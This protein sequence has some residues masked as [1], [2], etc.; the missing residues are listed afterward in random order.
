[1]T[2]LRWKRVLQWLLVLLVA[3]LAVDV[4]ALDDARARVGGG[5]DFD[6]RPSGGG[7][8]GGGGGDGGGIPIELVYLLI[9]LVVRY[10]ALGI[11]LVLVVGAVVVGR[12]VFSNLGSGPVS[13][14]R[15]APQRALPGTS[16]PRA[17]PIPGLAE[18]R[19]RDPGFSAVVLLDLV[20]LIH[21]RCLEA[22]G[23]REWDPLSP[24]VVHA[25]RDRLIAAHAGVKS[26]SDVVT[27]GV[28]LLKVERRGA[29]DHLVV[30]FESTRTE[31]LASGSERRVLV[32]EQW[33][34]RRAAGAT[35]LPP[36]AAER[37]G[38]PNCGA[39]IEVGPMGTC[40]ACGTP[41]TGGQLQ[42]QVAFT[43][44]LS[45]VVARVPKVTELPGGEEP[46]VRW[47][48]VEARDLATARA[49][50]LQRHPEFD[51]A[52]FE[53]RVGVVFHA[54]QTA[55]SANRWDDGRPF[56]T[57]RMY[58]TL[59][60]GIERYAAQGLRNQLDDVVLEQVRVAK[61]ELDAYY[62]AITV[63]LWASCIDAIVDRTG[64]VVGG[65]AQVPR[66]F[67]EYWT[68][69]RSAEGR[70]DSHGDRLAC[71]SCGAPL[72]R[73]GSDG[74]CGYCDSKITTGRFDW[75]LTRIEQPE[76]YGG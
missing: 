17:A 30:R 23:T 12:M 24:F 65:N 10:P 21:R 61:I 43:D 41:I 45:R 4:L 7:R 20:T 19:T 70:A 55:V 53:A 64:G 46:A 76:V 32:E 75:V 26:V 67:T 50:L 40:Q 1:M 38:C 69:V 35:S 59:R 72:D 25:A 8:G 31:Q 37:L 3:V 51:A 57:D 68:F 29:E 22:I 66:R 56:V 71:P 49:A 27:G 16:A 28:R 52:A 34:F 36:A 14:R 33:T 11:P 2:P 13:H 60:F 47:P 42:W 15:Q 44:L 39:S 54:L 74:I 63:R 62:E 18:L 9:Q 5:Q 48:T 73:I 6:R 58:Q